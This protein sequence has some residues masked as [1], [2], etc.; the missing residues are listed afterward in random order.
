[1]VECE[2]F[3]LK[4]FLVLLA[5]VPAVGLACASLWLVCLPVFQV[6]AWG[7]WTLILVPC[8]WIAAIVLGLVSMGMVVVT[9]E[10]LNS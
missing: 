7:W 2:G 1:M 8:S 4:T 3:K 6:M 9:I 10:T 5:V